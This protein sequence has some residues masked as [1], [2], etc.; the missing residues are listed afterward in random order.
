MIAVTAVLERRSNLIASLAQEQLKIALFTMISLFRVA[1]VQ[2]PLYNWLEIKR[3]HIELVESGKCR[4]LA[5]LPWQSLASYN[6]LYL[7]F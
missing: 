7:L 1:P 4:K 2:F 5:L 3:K 6:H